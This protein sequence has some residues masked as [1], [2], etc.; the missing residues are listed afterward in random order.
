MAFRTRAFRFEAELDEG[1]E[2]CDSM[3]N[4]RA[5]FVKH[6]RLLGRRRE[7][8]LIVPMPAHHC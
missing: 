5:R 6:E 8:V 2:H 1:K 3:L 4:D 7:F